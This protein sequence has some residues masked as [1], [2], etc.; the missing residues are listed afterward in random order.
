M[1]KKRKKIDP[2][3]YYPRIRNL[4]RIMKLTA[5]LIILVISNTLAVNSY[6]QVT[7]LSLNMSNSTVKD[8]LMEIEKNSDFF[9]LY[10]NELVDV[11]RRIDI[12]LTN[13]KVSDI[14][15]EVFRNTAV[16]YDIKDRQIILKT[17]DP[18]NMDK[19]IS[20]LRI[21]TG[22]VTDPTGA[23]LPGVTVVIKG[24]TQGTITGE[25]GTYTLSGV[26]TDAI[27]VFS[28]VGMKSKEVDA[29]GLTLINAMLD[30]ETI[31]LDEVVAVGYGS[32]KKSDLTGS[33]ASVRSEK[34]KD[35][36]DAN[37][38]EAL[39]GQIAGVQ[40]QQTSGAPGGEGLTIRVRGT[41]SITSGTEPLYVVDGYPIE[42]NA[43]SL[44]TT[45]D[46]ESIQILKDASSTAIYGSRGA[47]GVVI[48]KTKQGATGM[49]K[50]TYNGS[51]GFQQV[52]N[53]V[54]LMNRDEYLQ[55]F[56]D[57]HN[58]AWLDQTPLAGD[59]EHTINDPNS[60]RMQYPNS[61]MYIIPDSFYDSSNF[62]DTDWQDEL[63]RNAFTTKHDLSISGGTPSTTYMFSVAYRKQDGIQINSN[64]ERINVRSNITSEINDHLKVGLNVSGYINNY[65]SLDNGKYSPL[66][67]AVN[68]PP[69]YPVRN[70]DGTYGSMVRNYEIFPGDNSSPIGI[71]E[72][73]HNYTRGNMLLSSAFAE[74]KIL[75][76][77]V[78][79]FSIN[80]SVKNR[81][82]EFYQPS[83]VDL[84]ASRAPRP[85][86]GRNES[87]YDFDWVIE[88]TLNY[89]KNFDNSHQLN[90]LVGYTTQQHQWENARV[91]ASNFPNDQIKTLNAGQIVGGTSLK[92]KYN[93]IS[94]L[95]RVNYS[96]R[97]KYMI[98]GTLRSD[99]SSRFGKKNKW[100]MFPSA[101]LA[102]RISEE[103]FLSEMASLSNLKLRA[104]WGLV[105]NNKI[106]DYDAIG[107]LATDFYVLND[108][109]VNA[110]NPSTI[111]NEELGWE[112]TR[113]WNFGLDV[114]LFDSRIS[115]E[116]DV[117]ESKSVDLLL[118]VPI[119]T[120]TGYGSQQQNIGKVQNRGIEIGLSTRNM[121]HEFKW[122]TDFNIAF[123]KNEVLALG[124]EDRPIYG[125]A[126]SANNTFITTVGQPIATFYG[127]KYVGVF[128]TQEDLDK[129]PH[130][131]ADK[132]GDP[133]YEDINGDKKITADD[134]TFIGNNQPD[135]IFGFSNSF[136]YKNFDL[137]IQTN[138]V[139]GNELFSFFYRMVG[140]YHG[141]RN[142]LSEMV[143]RWQSDDD[144]GDGY[145]FR[146]NRNPKGLQKEPSS[147]WVTDGSF[148]RLRSVTLGYT[149]KSSFIQKLR[150]NSLRFY[151]TGQN[152]FTWTNYPGYDP[153][154]SSEGNGLSRG[155]DYSGYPSARSFLFGVNVGF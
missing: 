86:Q 52:E 36:A 51:V 62:V 140:I 127:Y 138:G 102:W 108:A 142:G 10:S 11:D 56:I 137:N 19:T 54:D 79:K 5:L 99:G 115:L 105:G 129:Y 117:Y 12:N 9:F 110:V 88:N 32:M 65:N 92:S 125:S 53:K 124:P 57:G 61:D 103:P 14:L 150:F 123:N 84:D 45:S 149:F 1:E 44:I 112:R 98:T 154:T 22:N 101:A 147:Y 113:Q 21:I 3:I 111:S 28:F 2:D 148:L 23:P 66:S 94:Y 15:D 18:G 155:G 106:G 69:I 133:H 27:L 89:N 24:T 128:M 130:L 76:D 80:G 121:I 39:V 78:Y 50:V 25:D 33:I 85:A 90:V 71:A 109:L 6:S 74:L 91:E 17:D 104:S 119:P 16:G 97:S 131:D 134:K 35:R 136:E 116:T 20:Q 68:M 126:P 118:D 114:S 26:S 64:Y 13:K 34:L 63:F 48:I 132:V 37:F 7:R 55:W 96:Y 30:E 67:F 59:L 77:L 145:H 82:N 144:R 38:G 42:G 73:V 139:Y 60:V 81:Q 40:I 4:V 151:L 49:P 83:F 135:F 107:R 43:F 46:I 87:W 120:I 95:G 70:S 146:A 75:P 47:N 122:N 143:D 29:S 152:L 41:G 8:V 93:L 31:G 58:Q 100:G 153:E 72:N 141:D